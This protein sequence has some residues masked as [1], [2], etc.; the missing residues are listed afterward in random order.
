LLVVIAIIAVL[1]A[2]L[3]PAVQ[4]AREAARRSQ[5]R[6]NLKQVGLALH[7]YNE[8]YG[9]F[10]VEGIW[11]NQTAPSASN[12]TW[13]SMI[14]PDLDQTALYSA[15]SFDQPIFTQMM[16]DGTSTIRSQKIIPLQCPSSDQFENP[17]HGFSTTCYAG[18]EGW[19][20]YDRG[21]EWYGGVFTLHRACK[22]QDIVDGTSNTIAVGEVNTFGF[23]GSRDGGRGRPRI[24]FGEPVFRSALVATGIHPDPANR[25]DRTLRRLQRADGNQTL[26]AW[27]GPW[28]SPHAYK[29][30]YVS[31]YAINS[32][33][34]GPSSLHVGGAHFLF[35][36]GSV[37]F[38]SDTIS[39]GAP[40]WNAE[41]QFGNIWHALHTT[42][43]HPNE[44][45]IAEGF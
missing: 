18:S 22:T 10:P 42:R 6:N 21:Q 3:L 7:N 1:V 27:W 30:T 38:I 33:W 25:T 2:L 5:C 13:I 24:G 37:K 15:I 4:Q 20:W 14:L 16:P 8:R 34:P 26:A 35:A 45:S 43:G 40:A 28:G 12:H 19:D 39:T 17:P 36:D 41:G 31:H 44:A 9:S 23:T 32:E 11:S 29:P